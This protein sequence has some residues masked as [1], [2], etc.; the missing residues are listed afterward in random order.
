MIE[1]RTHTYY[2]TSQILN[3]SKKKKDIS[4]GP[5]MLK[6]NKKCVLMKTQHKDMNEEER[7]GRNVK[8]DEFQSSVLNPKKTFQMR[9]AK[10]LQ[11]LV[12]HISFSLKN[13]MNWLD[14]IGKVTSA[15]FLSSFSISP[16]SQLYSF[17]LASTN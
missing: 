4:S 2:G 12:K 8:T 13:Q 1:N 9:W 17:F 16:S 10:T 5:V 11:Y 14:L 15:S 3:E 6:N 7:K